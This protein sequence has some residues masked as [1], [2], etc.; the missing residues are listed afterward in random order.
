MHGALIICGLKHVH[1]SVMSTT[2]VRPIQEGV[3]GLRAFQ[4]VREAGAQQD[5]ATAV[6]S[7]PKREHCFQG[8]SNAVSA[9]AM[10]CRMISLFPPLSSPEIDEQD[11][12]DVVGN[13]ERLS[14]PAQRF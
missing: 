3:S 5:D 11:L 7:C 6:S 1:S 10:A 13:R 2:V 14:A 12:V 4:N 8:R 9:I